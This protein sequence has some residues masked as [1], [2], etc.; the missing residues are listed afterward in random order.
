MVYL[1]LITYLVYSIIFLNFIFYQSP[2]P[3]P[4]NPRLEATSRALTPSWVPQPSRS[5][6]WTE[7]Q[8]HGQVEAPSPELPPLFPFRRFQ[9]PT[10]PEALTFDTQRP[11]I[12]HRVPIPTQ[13]EYQ[14]DQA[15]TERLWNG[16]F[17][18]LMCI[19]FI[20]S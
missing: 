17:F 2:E 11:K 6:P 7:A 9:G 19:G 15:S 13:L 12:G 4:L 16:K 1:Y 20:N 18:I 14:S 8:G 5:Q 3:K 10:K